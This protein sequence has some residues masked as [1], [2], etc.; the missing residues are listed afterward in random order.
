MRFLGVG[1]A[2]DLASLYLR[3]AEDGHEVKIFIGHPLCRDTLA[4]L[5]DRV[6]DWESEL[7]WVGAAKN[8]G[9]ILFENVGAGR[10]AI[11]DRLRRDGFNVI[12]SSAYGARLENDRAYAQR[13]LGDL[14]LSTA[15]VFE[16]SDV[17]EASRFIDQRPA[18]YVLKSNGPDAAT[19]VG[20]HRNGSDVLAL[21]TADHKSTASSFI[22]MDFVEGVEMGVGA[23]FNG[24]DF[25][26]P[27]CLDWEH[28]R[29][30]PGDLG[31]LTGEMGT[32]VTYSRSKR[33]FDRTLAKMTPL[34]RE[35][36][37][38]GY[39]NLNTLVNAKGIWPLEFTCRFGYPGYA[40]LD[41][42]QRTSWA[43]LFRSMLDRSAN[44]FATEPGFSVGIVITTPPFPYS[45]EHVSEPIGL[46]ILFE[47]DL[48]PA[49]RRNLHYGEVGLKED[50]LVTSGAS[51]YTLVV[52]GTGETIAA[53]R[54]AANVL[55]GKVV[56]PNARY[57]RDIGDKLIDGD[58]AKVEAWG[59][60]DPSVL[61]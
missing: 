17:E 15:A 2:A 31:E 18:R 32:V 30:F 40:I 47:G 56:V 55:A 37:Y 51:G 22:L 43:D 54:E 59:L 41:P 39:I 23:Y 29:F 46:P 9:C 34:L 42:L 28:K 4:G 61:P 38:C 20:R 8:D 49:E 57:R 27:A 16:F 50:V 60:L 3:L 25:L 45:R 7:E 26:E 58:F 33:F 53:A 21:L 12:G 35:N 5:I 13:I 6:E 36:G 1:E 10:G 44:R 48:S 24:A 19:F 11:Q 52:T 14:G